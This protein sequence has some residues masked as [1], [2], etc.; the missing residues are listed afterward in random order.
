MQQA[1]QDARTARLSLQPLVPRGET[2]GPARRDAACG[3][4]VRAPARVALGHPERVLAERGEMLAAEQAAVGDGLAVLRAA[5][6]PPACLLGHPAT[7]A[8]ARCSVV[9]RL[10]R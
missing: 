1:T 5:P 6:R 2:A 7:D 8:P 3:G 9:H 10:E 4:G